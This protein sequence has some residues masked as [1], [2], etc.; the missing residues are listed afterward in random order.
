MAKGYWVGCF[1]RVIDEDKVAAYRALAGPAITAA[2]GRFIAR[3]MPAKVYDS[4]IMERTV[5]VE[6][7]SV[8]A[9]IAAH[10]SP[11]YQ[12]ALAALDGGVEREIRIVEGVD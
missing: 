3:G 12:K 5:I 2:G 10:D 7:E 8:N 4:G 6:F 9:A 1:R 11:A